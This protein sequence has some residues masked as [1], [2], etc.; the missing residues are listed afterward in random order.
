M[1]KIFN[2]KIKNRFPILFKRAVEFHL[3]GLT[4]HSLR[5]R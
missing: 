1:E 4:V 2:K 5:L 3:D